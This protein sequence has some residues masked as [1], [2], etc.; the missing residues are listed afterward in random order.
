MYV[1]FFNYVPFL[2]LSFSNL[3]TPDIR[4]NGKGRPADVHPEEHVEEEARPAGRA[5]RDLQLLPRRLS[6][7]DEPFKCS[8]STF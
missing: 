5:E 8:E 3:F 2:I 7:L 1:T 4:Q 6:A